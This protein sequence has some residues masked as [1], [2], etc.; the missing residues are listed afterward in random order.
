MW[1]IVYPET[2]V[3]NYH[4]SLRNNSEEYSLLE[5]MFEAKL[6]LEE[7]SDKNRYKYSYSGN[8]KKNNYTY[9]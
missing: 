5:V 4:Y 1:P 8:K 2:S 3:R 6:S 7:Y 9:W